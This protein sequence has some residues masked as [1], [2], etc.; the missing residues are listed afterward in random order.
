M[1]AQT[2]QDEEKARLHSAALVKPSTFEEQHASSVKVQSSYPL[3]QCDECL[4]FF[5]SSCLKRDGNI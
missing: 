2:Q 3:L 1:R 5:P 4:P